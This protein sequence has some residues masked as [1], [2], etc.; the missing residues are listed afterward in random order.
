MRVDDPRERIAPGDAVDQRVGGR[1]GAD[2]EERLAPPLIAMVPAELAELSQRLATVRILQMPLK[3]P[4]L[5]VKEYWHRRFHA[6]PGGKWLRATIA[7][8]LG[9]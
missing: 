9:E 5:V 6:D 4:V 3:P 1:H 8:L 7:S 2:V